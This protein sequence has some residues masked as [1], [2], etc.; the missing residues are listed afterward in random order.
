MLRL[1]SRDWLRLDERDIRRKVV[2][3]Y[4]SGIPSISVRES[5]DRHFYHRLDAVFLDLE[6][7]ITVF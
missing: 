2:E 6:A 5:E 7:I 3:E 1:R 4:P